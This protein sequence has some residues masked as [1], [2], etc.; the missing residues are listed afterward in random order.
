MIQKKK[1][2]EKREERKAMREEKRRDKCIDRMQGST[3][4]YNTIQYITLH[5]IT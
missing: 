5:N 3:L 1:K 4:H 2:R